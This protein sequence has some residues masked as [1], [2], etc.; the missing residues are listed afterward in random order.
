MTKNN[1]FSSTILICMLMAILFFH[2]RKQNRNTQQ[3]LQ[4][5]LA[6][7]ELVESNLEEFKPK[8]GLIAAL[9]GK[10]KRLGKDVM[11]IELRLKS[12]KGQSQSLPPTSS[13]A[14]FVDAANVEKAARQQGLKIDYQKLKQELTQYASEV[15]GL[16][17]YTAVN[18]NNPN[19]FHSRNNLDGYQIVSKDLVRHSDGTVEGNVDPEIMRDLIAKSGEF[20]TA[21]LVSGDGDFKCFVKYLQEQNKQVIVV[22]FPDSTNKELQM[23]ADLYI[24]LN[25]S[26]VVVNQ[27]MAV[28]SLINAA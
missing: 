17:Y 7:L 12:L 1:T 9:Q 24:D 16:F 11:T 26:P 13:I 22:G 8:Q 25:L 4:Q 14:M 19:K 21:I 2:Q 23:M 18:K 10:V 20:G 5:T 6:R 27:P 3:M 15:V 28:K